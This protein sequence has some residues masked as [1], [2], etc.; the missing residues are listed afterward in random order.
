MLNVSVKQM[1]LTLSRS[2]AGILLISVAVF[3]SPSLQAAATFIET[4]GIVV[5]EAEHFDSRVTA[6][7]NTHQYVIVPDEV[8]A[9]DLASPAGQYKNARG[10][11]YLTTLPDSGE[12]RNNVDLQAAGP[13]VNY[14]VQ[15]TTPGEYQLY[16]RSLGYD[17][18][19]DSFYVSIVELKPASGGA[20]PDWYRLAPNPDTGDFATLQNLPFDGTTTAGWTGNGNPEVNNGGDG[21]DDAPVVW[22]ISKAGTYTI[23]VQQREDGNGLDALILQ[24]SS[25]PV[26]SNPGPAESG[27]SAGFFIGVHP[28]DQ[29]TTPGKTATFTVTPLVPAGTA[30]TYQWQQKAPGATTFTPVSGATSA[31]Y[32][33]PTATDAMNGTQYRVTLTSGGTTLTS[34]AATLIT[35]AAPPTV[36]GAFGSPDLKG[37]TIRFSEKV[38][39][40]TA[41]TL[42][43]YAITGLTLS[44]PKLQANGTDVFLTTTVQTGSTSYTITING[45][46]DVAGNAI[47]NGQ[48][49]FAGATLTAGGILQKYWNNISGNNI[50]ALRADTRFP[51]SPT[52][53]TIEPRL[54]YPPNGANEAGSNYGN[55]LAGWLVPT[56]TADYV[57]FTCSDDPNE[58]YLS[59]DDNPANKK[60]IAQETAW[61]N[62]RQWTTSG[63]GSDL[64][65]KRSDQFAATEWP[66][67][68]TIRL[69]A[70]KS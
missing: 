68:N 62:A 46:K 57:F 18:A 51:D 28:A 21:G 15:I 44:A 24:L 50:A 42:A 61:S 23:R 64:T 65:A 34:G 63:G 33:T 48:A 53:T 39:Q 32:T 27:V 36:V 5:I 3:L 60:L 56:V 29:I 31:S 66:S 43:N 8:S 19:S 67:G 6:T 70:G 49:K 41:E 37:V 52:F 10:G 69:T 12:N 58:F 47:V 14:K 13:Q 40:A 38:T 17:G 22:T 11:R 59:T 7:D 9:A 20:G 1:V 16:L 2:V 4:G 26:P 54:E 35:D 30:V 45:V 25:K 55:M